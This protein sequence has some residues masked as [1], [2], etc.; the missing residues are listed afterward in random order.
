MIN[1]RDASVRV[2]VLGQGA[3]GTVYKMVHVPSLTIVAAKV[4]EAGGWL[5]V[6]GGCSGRA[7]WEVEAGAEEQ[8]WSRVPKRAVQMIP[9]YDTQKRHLMK[10]ELKALYKN[11]TPF[12]C[13]MRK[14]SVGFFPFS[15]FWP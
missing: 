10:K 4:I 9:M 8:L 5:R 7:W 13:T 14:F 12:N 3:S 1:F 11:L 6:E 15:C 2:E